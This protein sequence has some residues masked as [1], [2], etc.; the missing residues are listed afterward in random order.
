[1]SDLKNYY[2]DLYVLFSFFIESGPKDIL[3]NQIVWYNF[4]YTV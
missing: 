1:M 4:H 3:Y 2:K